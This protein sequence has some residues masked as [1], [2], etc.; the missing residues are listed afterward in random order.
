MHEEYKCNPKNIIVGIG[1]A[2]RKE[3]YKFEN[4]TQST[5][6]N[7]KDFIEKEDKLTS[8]D[9]VGYT[10]AQLIEVGI[11]KNNIFDSE[12]DTGIDKNFFSHYRNQRNEE[13]EGRFASIVGMI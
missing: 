7:W 8:I 10:I 6:S 4:P 12:I 2:I 11:A 9:I 1:P 3:S 13:I 5:L